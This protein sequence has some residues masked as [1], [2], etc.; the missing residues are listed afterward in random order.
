MPLAIGSRTLGTDLDGDDD[1]RSLSQLTD[2]IAEALHPAVFGGQ[3]FMP[4]DRLR[5]IQRC[6]SRPNPLGRALPAVSPMIYS[7]R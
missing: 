6:A 2:Q 4:D 5:V 1:P 3:A 7:R